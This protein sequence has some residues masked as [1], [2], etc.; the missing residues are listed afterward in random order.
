MKKR[1]KKRTDEFMY[2]AFGGVTMLGTGEKMP[3]DDEDKVIVDGEEVVKE[4][5]RLVVGRDQFHG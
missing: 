4:F 2:S 3:G 1:K 5:V